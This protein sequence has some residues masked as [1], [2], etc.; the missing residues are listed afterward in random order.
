MNFL[1]LILLFGAA[2]AVDKPQTNGEQLPMYKFIYNMQNELILIL[3]YC[4]YLLLKEDFKLDE[5]VIDTEGPI[6]R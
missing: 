5:K 6:V 2:F 4:E 3:P 1:G